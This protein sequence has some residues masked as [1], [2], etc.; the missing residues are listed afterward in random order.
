MLRNKSKRALE[1]LVNLF[2]K[3]HID[4]L[5]VGGVA[6][7]FYGSQRELADIDVGILNTS[8]EKVSNLI[9]QSGVKCQKPTKYKN[10]IWDINLMTFLYKGQE[11]DIFATKEARI[12]N[13]KTGFWEDWNLDKVP[14]YEKV[15]GFHKYKLIPLNKLIE[16]KSKIGR[17]VDV[18][19]II[20]LKTIYNKRFSLNQHLSVKQPMPSFTQKVLQIVKKIPKGQTLSY[21]QVAAQAGNPKAYRAVGNILNKNYDPQIPCH[22]VIRSNGQLGGY[23]RGQ[24]LKKG[25]LIKEL[26]PVR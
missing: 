19:D 9:N 23:N 6:S 4:Y 1:W 17:E 25:L 11:I 22:R 24:E 2:D 13:K 3:N 12:Y 26:P 5:L 10:E 21:K 8:L 14:K 20:E 18:A 15:Y 7:V 16:Y